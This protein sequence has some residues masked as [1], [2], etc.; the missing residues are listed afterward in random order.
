VK[1]SN[2]KVQLRYNWCNFFSSDKSIENFHLPEILSNDELCNSSL[3]QRSLVNDQFVVDCYK[4]KV[5]TVEMYNLKTNLLENTFQKSEES[6]ALVEGKSSHCF[7][8]SNNESLF[9]YCRGTNSITIYLMKTV[10]KLPQRNLVFEYFFW[11][12]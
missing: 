8:I 10:W 6:A 11:K 5:Q 7:A 1:Q 4:N 2:V 12:I 9:A 3:I